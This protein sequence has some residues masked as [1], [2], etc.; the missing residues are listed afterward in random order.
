V[1]CSIRFKDNDEDLS[2]ISVLSLQANHWIVGRVAADGQSVAVG[3]LQ[4]EVDQHR[5]HDSDGEAL[6]KVRSGGLTNR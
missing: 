4:V 6:G 1:C 5:R 2:S 3:H